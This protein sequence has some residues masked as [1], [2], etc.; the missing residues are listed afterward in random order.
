MSP[1][2]IYPVAPRM[3]NSGQL[4]ITLYCAGFIPREL[5]EE[6]METRPF[7]EITD[8]LGVGFLLPGKSIELFLEDVKTVEFYTYH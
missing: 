7:V 3:I 8:D 5:L 2:S 6:F 4:M 1:P